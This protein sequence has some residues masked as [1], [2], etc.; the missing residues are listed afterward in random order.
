M[1]L[2]DFFAF[3]MLHNAAWIICRKY[4]VNG[5]VLKLSDLTAKVK[6]LSRF[7]YELSECNFCLSHHVGMAVVGLIWVFGQISGYFHV[8]LIY[9]I[10]PLMSAS[11]IH[12]IYAK[13]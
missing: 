11:L 6:F 3:V 5:A 8:P 1:N 13:R 7:F 12:M 2:S 4:S 9:L 10:Y